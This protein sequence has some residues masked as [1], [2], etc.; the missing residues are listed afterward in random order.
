MSNDT[1]TAVVYAKALLSLAKVG[2]LPSSPGALAEQ[3]LAHDMD[4][5][6]HLTQMLLEFHVPPQ[7]SRLLRLDGARVLARY[8]EAT[9]D[10]GGLKTIYASETFNVMPRPM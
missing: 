4:E 3:R 1:F 10:V 8:L 2:H 7:G 6:L 5:L 9:G